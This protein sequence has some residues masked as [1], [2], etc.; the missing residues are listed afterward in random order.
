MVVD[1]GCIG[2]PKMRPMLRKDKHRLQTRNSLPKNP[3]RNGPKTRRDPKDHV[4]L[5]TFFAFLPY[6]IG[7]IPPKNVAE[8]ANEVEFRPA[9]ISCKRQR[10]GKRTE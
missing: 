7:I 9:T 6:G 8:A 2:V 1:L 10:Y 5:A 3:S 4:A